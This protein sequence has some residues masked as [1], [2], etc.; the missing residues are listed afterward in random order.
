MNI[1]L[2]GDIAFQDVADIVD[3]ALAAEHEGFPEIAYESWEKLTREFADA[4]APLMKTV[5][6]WLAA[7]DAARAEALLGHMVRIF[8]GHLVAALKWVESAFS[9]ADWGEAMRRAALARRRFPDSSFGFVMGGLALRE[10]GRLDEADMAFGEAVSRFPA[11]EGAVIHW[12]NCATRRGDDREADRRLA[13]AREAF[14]NSAYGYSAGA[15]VLRSLGHVD[16]MEALLTEA[17][18]KLPDDLDLHVQWTA[19]ASARQDWPEALRR[20]DIA[21]QRFPNNPRGVLPAFQALTAMDRQK[22]ADALIQAA[23]DRF[24][25]DPQILLNWTEA[26]IGARNWAEAQAR[27]DV[28]CQRFPDLPA[29]YFL[30]SVALREDRRLA[31]AI[32]LLEE[33]LRRFPSDVS[34]LREASESLVALHRLDEAAALVDRALALRPREASFLHRRIQIAMGLQDHA[35]AMTVW[36]RIKS[37]TA[38]DARLCNDIAWSILK[39]IPVGPH[40]QEL[41]SHLVNERDPGGRGWQPRLAELA[42]LRRMRKDLADFARAVLPELEAGPFQDT[43]LR[44]LKSALLIDYS[45]ADILG[46]ITE[47]VSAGRTALTSHLFSQTYTNEKPGTTERFQAI[48]EAYLD[49]WLAVATPER[50][51]NFVEVLGYL[52]FAAIFSKSDFRRLVRVCAESIDIAALRADD[53]LRTPASV[54]G[55]IVSSAREAAFAPPNPAAVARDRRLKIAVCIS[56]Q[57]RGYE[58]AFPTWTRLGLHAHDTHIF[59]HTWKDIGRNWYRFWVFTQ[60]RELLWETLRRPDSIALLASRYPGMTAACTGQSTRTAEQLRRFYGTPDVCVEDDALPPFNDKS[61]PWK[62]HSKIE[63]AH[64][65]ALDSGEEFDLYIRIRPDREVSE[66]SEPDWHAVFEQSKRERMLFPD[67]PLDYGLFKC[68]H[69]DQFAAG[70][71][72]VMDIYTSTFSATMDFLSRSEVPLDLPPTLDNHGSMAYRTFYN[73]VLSMPIPNLRFGHLF[74]PVALSPGDLVPLIEADMSGRAADEFDREFLTACRE[75]IR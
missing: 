48:F 39:A 33:P 22:E 1:A 51:R 40:A 27:S 12:S 14:P 50:M 73:G 35:G 60:T 10:A 7:K 24:P 26:A 25:H 75:T 38:I 43:T 72:E 11:D 68:T 34:L 47:Y 70:C 19:A 41:L 74:D 6:S 52:N 9:R 13:L 44:V 42:T 31:E 49:E 4:P 55:R 21:R 71:R 17:I 56:G 32:A 59:V 67:L 20:A 53:S 23:A 16:R 65:M 2:N 63:R 64:Q 57:L 45:D 29:S 37:D 15:Q 54:I 58:R 3:E 28:L 18:E 36:R 8:P 30:A 5:E 69:G 66:G 62:M 46:Y 61:V